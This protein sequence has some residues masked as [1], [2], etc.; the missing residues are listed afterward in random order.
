[1]AKFEMEF[2]LEFEFSTLAAVLMPAVRNEI[3]QPLHGSTGMLVSDG[4][5][6]TSNGDVRLPQHLPGGTDR[7]DS[8]ST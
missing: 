6:L 4:T 7:T 2:R 1:M 8:S 3:Q 5:P